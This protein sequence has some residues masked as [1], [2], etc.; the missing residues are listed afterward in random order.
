MQRSHWIMRCDIGPGNGNRR[1][2]LPEYRVIFLVKNC[3]KE[4]LI[5]LLRTPTLLL[6]C[7][8]YLRTGALPGT[9]LARS[10]HLIRGSITLLAHQTIM[11]EL[12]RA[13]NFIATCDVPPLQKICVAISMGDLF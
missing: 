5:K 4:P 10:L 8:L 13:E 7:S 9:N 1:L 2:L 3:T 12:V 11:S 6:R